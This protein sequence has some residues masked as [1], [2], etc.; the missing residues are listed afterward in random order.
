M[1]FIYYSFSFFL[2]LSFSTFAQSK[3]GLKITGKVLDT[4]T[5][6]PIEYASI[7]VTDQQ[8][9]KMI[10]GTITDAN[11]AF[12]ITGILPGT[13][14]ISID[15]V[16]YQKKTLKD[17]ALKAGDKPLALNTILL[18]T[19]VKAL[20]EVT[21]VG[22]AA[23]VENQIDKIVYNAANDITSQGGAAID[24]LKKVPQVT[25]D[26]DGNVELQGNPNIRFLINGK[27]SSVFGNSLA[28][29][30]ASIPASQI[31]SIEAIT[32]PGAKYDAQGT[33][34]IINIILKDNRVQGINGSINLTAGTRLENGSANLNY[35]RN[36]FGVNAFFSGNEQLNS[37]KPSTQ[38]RT[39]TNARTVTRLLQDGYQDFRRSGYRAGIG[40]DWDINKKTALIGALGYNDFR[41]RSDGFT[42]IQQSV[43]EGG[44]PISSSNIVRNSNSKGGILDVDWSLNYKRKFNKEKQEL[45][46]LYSASIGKP[47]N[48]YS[49]VQTYADA[50]LP[51]SGTLGH[52]P[53]TDRQTNISLDYAHPVTK[54]F[55]VETGIKTVIQHINTV[56]DISVFNASSGNYS[57]DPTQS[58]QLDYQM[59]VYAG[60]LSTTFSLFNYLNIKAG[61]RYEHTSVLIDFP[62]TSIPAYDNFLPSF[63]V[64]RD[65]KHD[66][67]FKL[68]FTRRIERAEYDE[69][70]PFKNLSDP[71]NITAG[72]P[73]LKPEI[74]NNF[75]LG[76]SRSFKNGGN[77]YVALF[78][79]INTNDIKPYTTFYPTYQIGDSTYQ[80]VSVTIRQNIGIEYNSGLSISG[81]VPL[82]DHLNIRGNLMATH[83]SVVN[84]LLAGNVTNGMNYR[85]NLNATYQLPKDLIL[86][87]FGNYSSA[88]NTIQGKRPQ[89]F[90][91]NLA[92]RKQ[93]WHKKASI[94]ITAT[95]P[96][97]QY[98]HQVITVRT[99]NYL[100]YNTILVPYRSFGIS[101]TYKFG[102]L[103]F[104]KGKEPGNEF[105]NA[106]SVEN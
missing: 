106:P 76:Y 42:Q 33:G 12:E 39:S 8:T 95:N 60:Y 55:L 103:E 96:F 89:Q 41:N 99:A 92:F 71:Y 91:Y 79:R 54:K 52:T 22:Q 36:N 93:F 83:K 64:S 21:V 5:N 16:G 28:D 32:S 27:P 53:G 26:I 30:L 10:T 56:A 68:A 3:T 101:F 63:V 65:F 43:T 35:R 80:N 47:D 57:S 25:V 34:G 7:G 46:I 102:K 98:I 1:K 81:S 20:D 72:N 88:I 66:Q 37:R 94:G 38:D 86:E 9:N 51:Y 18:T 13:F 2:L 4:A 62:N 67:S 50:G 59:K 69:I 105:I 100:S 19:S 14:T 58:Y 29:A 48:S 78:E 45:D 23:I 49:Q 70:N 82:T 15:F 24:V 90:T 104:K 6:Q 17:I 84:S 61:A 31:K 97:N 75:E 87:G 40:F 11:G 73:L 74:G 44:I 85:F 77:V